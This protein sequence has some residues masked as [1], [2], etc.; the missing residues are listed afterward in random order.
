MATYN[1]SNKDLVEIDLISGN[2][3]DSCIMNSDLDSLSS[4]NVFWKKIDI[5][6]S[7]CNDSIFNI[8]SFCECN[9]HRSSM[10]NSRFNKCKFEKNIFSGIS[11][12]KGK[13]HNSRFS[14][15][16][17]ESCTMQRLE[18][19]KSIIQNTSFK[20]FEGV[21]SKTINTVF[22][23]CYFEINYGSGMNGFSSGNFENCIFMNCNFSGYP[24]RG[25][26]VTNCTFINCTGEL[27][28]DM[29]AI[30]SS[31]LPLVINPTNRTKKPIANKEKA[32]ELLCEVKNG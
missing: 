7:N 21:Y 29:T 30:N 8:S 9:F 15:S 23:N 19:N 24:L 26:N 25:A 20:D 17:F 5:K 10:I 11:L 22:L 1:Y 28:D 14:Q 32:L 12:I 16:T 18:F 31:G 2:F 3:D 6:D 27:S 4:N 13:F